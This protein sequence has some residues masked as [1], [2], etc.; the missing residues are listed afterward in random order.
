MQHNRNGFPDKTDLLLGE[1]LTHSTFYGY[2]FKSERGERR[3]GK[4][5][6]HQDKIIYV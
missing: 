4:I 1:K 2:E 3:R 5:H 6:R